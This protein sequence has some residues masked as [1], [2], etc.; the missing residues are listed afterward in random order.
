MSTVSSSMGLCDEG[1]W[2]PGFRF[3]PTDEELVLYYLKFK[4]CRRKLKLD[5]IREIDVY[6][7]EPGELPG[8]SKLKTGDRQWFFFSPRER[9]YPNA[10]RLSRATRNGHWKV[11]GKDRIIKYNSRNVGVKKTL[12]FYQGRAP[13]GERTDWV[14]HEYTLD[15]DELKRCK[16][17]KDYYALYKLYKKSGPG[18][19]NGEQY[20]APFKEE[21]WNDG[22][23]QVLVHSD[24]QEPQ[25]NIL[26]EVTSVDRERANV[27]IQL[28][29]DDIEE[30]LQQFTNDP[31]LELPSVSGIHQ[32]DSVVQV[33]DKEETAST[34]IDTYSQNHILPEADKVLNLSGQ[35]SDLHPCFQ[36]TQAGLFQLQSFESEVSS[37]PK[38]REEEDFL[39]IDDLI[40]PEPTLVAN[41]NPLG[42]SE[43]DGLNELELFHDANMFLRDLG[44]VVPETFLDPY[45]SADGGIL[46]ANDVNGHL[47]YDQMGNGFW[48]NETENSFS[49]PEPHQQFGTQPNLGVG[50]ES[51]SSAAPEIR[52]N[53]IANG[54]GS[55]A[56]KFS[57]NLWAFVESIP[58]TPASASENVN[59][60]FQRMSSFSRL[61]LNTL[62]T[63]N[64]N[65]AIGNP[66]T[67]ARRTGTN[68]GFF[69]FSILGVLCAILWVLLGDVRLQ[70]R[71]I[72]S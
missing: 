40:G 65:V 39:E 57:S 35:P 23:C 4:V 26:D 28:S 32:F 13:N 18:P 33:D 64:A 62:N 72:A 15:E 22:E 45:L 36:F 29:S 27:Q 16:N 59:R 12:V 69:L 14:M 68:K 49:F 52:D 42:N 50:Y 66:K 47:Q 37:S 70:E 7:W 55:S 25:V 2:P 44:P 24:A 20:G 71:G 60:T 3:H 67:S 19:K 10:S 34:M 53:Q 43:F 17:V 30:L 61:R 9:R 1:D 41:V 46:V 48:E 63:F 31:V 5:I 11:T 6:K 58:T 51:V 38:Y 8:Q 56:S 21:N 54:G